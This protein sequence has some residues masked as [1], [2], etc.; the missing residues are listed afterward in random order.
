MAGL[1]SSISISQN[2]KE[3]FIGININVIEVEIV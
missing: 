3:E 2:D 1:G